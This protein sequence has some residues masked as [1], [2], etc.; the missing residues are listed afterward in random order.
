[1]NGDF[2]SKNGEGLLRTRMSSLRVATSAEGSVVADVE[3]CVAEGSVADADA[4]ADADAIGARN[5]C[6]CCATDQALT[7]RSPF[8]LCHYMLARLPMLCWD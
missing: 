2:V 8:M 4:R 5:V 7:H 3:L 6:L 1:M